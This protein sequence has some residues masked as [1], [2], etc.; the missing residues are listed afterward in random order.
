MP[1]AACTRSRHPSGRDGHA[2]DGPCLWAGAGAVCLRCRII[3]KEHPGPP[4]LI[5]GCP[6]YRA[7]DVPTAPMRLK[8]IRV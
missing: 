4:M 5:A 2:P 1:D 3:R 8:D 6:R 7:H